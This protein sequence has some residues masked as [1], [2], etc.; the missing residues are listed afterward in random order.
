M[1]AGKNTDSDKNILLGEACLCGDLNCVIY[2][3]QQGADIHYFCDFAFR[4]ASEKG[5]FEIVKFL[6]EKGAH[7][8]AENDFAFRYASENGY[9]EI[10]KFLYDK[11]VDVSAVNNQAIRY[12]CANGHLE[13]V[14]FLYEKGVDIHSYWN[15]S[16]LVSPICLACENGHLQIVRFLCEKGADVKANNNYAITS[17]MRKNYFDI[18]TY[19]YE[20]GAKLNAYEEKRL[21][22]YIK[23]Q[24]KR[25][26]WAA[27]KIGS[28]WIPICYDLK[29][30]CG[31]RMMEKGWNR[32]Q[33]LC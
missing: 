1:S 28:W 5:H 23:M 16:F 25:R 26:V 17:A 32:I 6:Y 20:R 31:K 2:L 3:L 12:A 19:L 7:H 15:T 18:A 27:N 4:V 8:R 9:V 13:V 14:K 29:R 24:Q 11:G 22:K 21:L 30:N 10:V 33:K